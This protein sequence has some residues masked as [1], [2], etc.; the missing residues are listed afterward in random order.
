MIR[1]HKDKNKIAN[2]RKSIPERFKKSKFRPQ[3]FTSILPNITTILA[4]C[5]GMTAIRM[6][7]IE[8]FDAA[9]VAII[10][11]GVL[12]GMDGRLARLLGSTSRIGAELD[13]FSDL[14]SFGA[15]PGIVL[16]LKSLHQWGEAGWGIVLFYTACVA[17]RLARF[18]VRTKGEEDP[19]W[20]KSFFTGVPSPA[21]A[22]LAVWPLMFEH[23]LQTN[24][25]TPWIFAT[26]IIVAGSLMVSR[27]PTYSLKN[28]AIKPS[29]VLPIML[30]VV[31]FAAAVYTRPWFCLTAVGVAY[32]S[33]LPVS[34]KKHEELKKK[35]LNEQV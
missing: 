2:F 18:N 31:L 17:L 26:F 4:M 15:A 34:L 16:Y 9:V 1:R 19:Q 33:L 10:M 23:T 29:F 14:L 27:W 28:F 11:A 22:Y 30:L 32:I 35:Y 25:K 13:S 6:A 12:D 5:C 3:T 8:R 20:K 21:G 24:I 7:M